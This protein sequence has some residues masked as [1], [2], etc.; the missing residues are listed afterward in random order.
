MSY[1]ERDLGEADVETLQRLLAS[2]PEYA[3]RVTGHPP[4]PSDALSALISVPPDFDPEGKCAIGLWDGCDLVAFA[5]VLLGYPNPE[6][7]FVGLMVVHGDRQG[8]GLGR[9][10]HEG[11]LQRVR[12]EPFVHTM[13][14]ALVQTVAPTVEPFIQVLGYTPTGQEKPYRYDKLSSTV[15]FW[16]RPV[17]PP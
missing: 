5:D 17:D 13:R 15:A 3:E 11:V 4:G 12:R 10:L 1:D 14:L 8:E 2:V 7:A 16:Q 9:R 6:V